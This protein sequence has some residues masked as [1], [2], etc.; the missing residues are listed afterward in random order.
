MS[1]IK[2]TI[3]YNWGDDLILM[4][5]YDDCIV[6]VS[7][8]FGCGS[9]VVYDHSKVINKLVDS[10]MNEEEAHEYFEYNM[11]G[12]Y[13]GDNTPSFIHLF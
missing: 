2:E 6:G 12:A 7:E 10:G 13:V 1:D 11:L 3:A 5:G 8:R 4:D 9:H